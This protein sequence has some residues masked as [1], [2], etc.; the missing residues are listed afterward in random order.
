MTPESIETSVTAERAGSAISRVSASAVV[1]P[2]SVPTKISTRDLNQREYVLVE[3]ETEDGDTGW[4]YTYAGTSGALWIASAINDLIAPLLA[5]RPAGA[6]RDNWSLIYQELL[7]VGRRGGLLRALSAVDIAA[8]DLLAKIA[9]LPLYRLLGG[10]ENRIAAYASGGYY[11]PGDAVR[12]VVDELERYLEL[13]FES[14]KIKVGG[15]TL[16]EDVARVKA[17]RETIGEG[18]LLALDANNAWASSGDA[19]Q[20]IRAFDPYDIWWIEEPLS[21]DDVAGHSRVQAKSPIPVATGEIE[22]T[23]WGFAELLRQDSCDILQP[24]ACVLGGISEWINVAQAAAA[25]GRTVAPHWHANLHAQLSSAF[26]SCVTVEYFAL[27]EGI[28]NFEEI[29]SNRL[30]VEDGYLILPSGPGLGIELDE[31]AV[32]RFTVGPRD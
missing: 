10:G 27:E 28:Y 21:P 14:F 4:G 18:R 23:R 15:T 5:G 20:A 7:L 17:A 11:R 12:N 30:E 2:V 31:E 32:A 26:P 16:A 24:D 6:I 19:L 13:G 9:G 29:V 1:I 25:F 22:A 3:I 8:W